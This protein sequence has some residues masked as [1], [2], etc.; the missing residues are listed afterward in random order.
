M[1]LDIF[2]PEVKNLVDPAAELEKLADGFQFIEGPVWDRT[3]QQLFF[4][5]IPANTMYRFSAE[6]GV[7]VHR[8]PSNFSNGLAIDGA[9]R[10]IACE[11]S[12]RR[13]TREGKDGIEVLVERYDGKRLNS[14]NDVIVIDD[15]SL[16]FS[17]PHYGLME[18]IGGPAEA[19]LS[20]RGVYRLV[21]GEEPLLLV[22]DFEAPNGL[23]LTADGTQLYIDD[24]IRGH[25]RLFA[26]GDDW[27]LSG[28]DLFIELKGEQDGAPDGMKLDAR[29]NIFCTG[30]GGVWI[31]SPAGTPLGRICV[32]EVTANLAWGEGGCLYMTSSTSLYRLQCKTEG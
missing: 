27:K 30:P 19:E 23:A 28:G 21:P 3:G 9:G 15:G 18:G 14:P 31:C 5:D 2:E 29:G 6:K 8:K 22:D 17:D 10:L 26:V 11:H 1:V 25:I 32:P 24:T 13:L 16:I 7:E 4:S 12:T 20:F